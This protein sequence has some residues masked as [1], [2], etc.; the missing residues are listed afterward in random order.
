M[1][2]LQRGG[3]LE[4]GGGFHSGGGSL[5]ERLVDG[6]GASPITMDVDRAEE[7]VTGVTLF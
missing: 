5:G 7:E 6:L 3:W 2:V 4:S 1:E